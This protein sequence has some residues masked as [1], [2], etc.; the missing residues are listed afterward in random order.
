MDAERL[1]LYR[2]GTAMSNNERPITESGRGAVRLRGLFG[3]ETE[4]RASFWVRKIEEEAMLRQLERQLQDEHVIERSA[5]TTPLD[6]DD[7]GW[8]LYEMGID[9]LPLDDARKLAAHIIVRLAARV[10]EGTDR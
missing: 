1:G 7:L 8:T 5:G 6:V 9:D 2:K 3:G 10:S 4:E